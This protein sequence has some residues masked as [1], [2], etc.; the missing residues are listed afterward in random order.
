MW[1]CDAGW[2]CANIWPRSDLHRSPIRWQITFPITQPIKEKSPWHCNFHQ[3][4]YLQDIK[5]KI[6]LIV[7]EY[8]SCQG[9]RG[10][11]VKILI[12]TRSVIRTSLISDEKTWWEKVEIIGVR[13]DVQN[14]KQI[15]V[16]CGWVGVKGTN[17]FANTNHW[18]YWAY[19]TENFYISVTCKVT[20]F[21][22]FS[23]LFILHPN[24]LPFYWT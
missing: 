2:L 17:F 8:L 3:N 22:I 13:K 16:R 24:Q 10:L 4:R 15:W 7:E 14:P 11:Q 21:Y 20:I 5:R 6:E 9:F 12:T 1:K 18:R 23:A 19:S